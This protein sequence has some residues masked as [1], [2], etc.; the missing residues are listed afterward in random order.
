[1]SNDRS[2]AAGASK[3]AEGR[4][5]AEEDST[6]GALR[7]AVSQVCGDRLAN[8]R[9]QRQVTTLTGLA[10]NTQ[11]PCFPVDIIEFEER[12]LTCA[13]PQS[14]EHKQDGVIAAAQC[15]GAVDTVQQ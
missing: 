7:P 13:Q 6:N 10:P 4:S 1:M 3:A 2:N 11:L 14:G 9:G 15:C 5:D 8:V 12:H